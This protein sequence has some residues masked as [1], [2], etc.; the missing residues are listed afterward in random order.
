MVKTVSSRKSNV[1]IPHP[2]D[3]S[4]T[5][6]PVHHRPPPPPPFPCVCPRQASM[7][8]ADVPD[9][10]RGGGGLGSVVFS[11]CFLESTINIQ[12]KGTGVLSTCDTRQQAPPSLTHITPVTCHRC[13]QTNTLGFKEKGVLGVESFRK[14]GR[15]GGSCYPHGYDPHRLYTVPSLCDCFECCR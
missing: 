7:T 10:Q 11:E 8:V 1:W 5:N 15:G 13:D 6:C 2:G 3:I 14:E 12:Q 4:P 9:L